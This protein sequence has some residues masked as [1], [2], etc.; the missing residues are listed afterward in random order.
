M[1]AIPG[2]S[3]QLLNR[4]QEVLLT[5]ASW[6]FAPCIFFSSDL[7]NS[8]KKKSTWWLALNKQSHTPAASWPVH[9]DWRRSTQLKLTSSYRGQ[10]R[11]APLS[12]IRKDPA[13]ALP[14]R[15]VLPRSF[16]VPGSWWRSSLIWV[17]WI[18]VCRTLAHSCPWG[19]MI[20][21]QMK[22]PPPHHPPL[23]YRVWPECSL[24]G[25]SFGSNLTFEQCVFSLQRLCRVMMTQVH[26]VFACFVTLTAT[27][28]K[29][30]STNQF[31][32]K[33]NCKL[34]MF[35]ANGVMCSIYPLPTQVRDAIKAAG[36]TETGDRRPNLLIS[37]EFFF[38]LF[39]NH[40]YESAQRISRWTQHEA[41][42]KC[43]SV[44]QMSANSDWVT[45][46]LA[47]CWTCWCASR[48]LHAWLAA[49]CAAKEEKTVI[50]LETCPCPLPPICWIIP[51]LKSIL[52]QFQSHCCSM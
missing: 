17:N 3:T 50:Y 6:L 31:C 25:F 48:F 35:Q 4:D 51:R 43:V 32:C 41:Q 18:N 1:T 29:F 10:W 33:C 49:G 37:V 14:A 23:R 19:V 22:V 40:N 21:V 46:K 13:S 12:I 2:R 26:C 28:T 9:R 39:Y 24:S 38:F 44:V 7:F 30:F 8:L 5:L 11:K 20:V 45:H 16:K 52:D 36:M 47:K 34:Q 42:M 15:A 27:T